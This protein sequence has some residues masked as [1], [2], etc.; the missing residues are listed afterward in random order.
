MAA[1]YS[2]RFHPWIGSRYFAQGFGG[3]K[4]LLLGESHYSANPADS[5][6][7]ALTRMVVEGYAMGQKKLRFFKTLPA[8]VADAPR[9]ADLTSAQYRFAWDGLS[10]YN[11]VQDLLPA[12]RV[13][14][15]PD[16]WVRA[17]KPFAETLDMLKPDIVLIAGKQLSRQVPDLP[18]PIA[19]VRITHPSAFGFS[20]AAARVAVNEQMPE[21]FDAARR[22][23][24]IAAAAA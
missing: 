24:R 5:G 10:F 19:T 12:A 7:T 13:R 8:L 9:R 16:M 2:A 23:F 17:A 18:I 21:G 4:I 11:Y 6:N 1:I 15:T 20:Y 14:P 22:A 3:A